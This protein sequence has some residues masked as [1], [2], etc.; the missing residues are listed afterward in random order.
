MGCRFGYTEWPDSLRKAKEYYALTIDVYK[1][2]NDDVGI[3]QIEKLIAIIES[4]LNGVE[5]RVDNDADINIKR[6]TYNFFHENL[7]QDHTTTIN[8]GVSLASVLFESFSTIEAERL[9]AKLHQISQRVH[10][11][12]HN[13]TTDAL[14][15]L[16]HVKVRSA[17][18]R[19]RPGDIFQALRYESDDKKIVLQGPVK[20]PRNI[21]MEQSFEEKCE[22]VVFVDGTP[23]ICHGL[24]KATQLNGKIGNLKDLDDESDRYTIHFEDKSLKPAKVKRGNLRIIFDLPDAAE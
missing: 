20:R 21:D 24:Q 3:Q 9:V 15:L 2:D 19:S 10:G 18:V 6:E 11:V 22:N 13:S 1:I 8:S 12:D 17:C 4:R 16:Q 14:S 7:G 23:V 5:R